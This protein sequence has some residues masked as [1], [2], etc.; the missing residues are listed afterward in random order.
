[1]RVGR[2]LRA[3]EPLQANIVVWF[4][5]CAGLLD[6]YDYVLLP[7]S[8]YHL[9]ESWYGGKSMLILYPRTEPSLLG[10]CSVFTCSSLDSCVHLLYDVAAMLSTGGPHFARPVI[11]R[12]GSTA[13]SAPTLQVELYPVRFRYEHAPNSSQS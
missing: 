7:Q 13:G 9:L 12:G 4:L 11:E 3:V 6:D 8:A 2:D 5:K 1:M 10:L